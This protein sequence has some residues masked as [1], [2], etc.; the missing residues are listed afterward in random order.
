MATRKPPDAWY[1]SYDIK[2]DE[3]DS[4]LV[5]GARLMRL[6]SYRKG[7]SLRFAA[8]AYQDHGPARRHASDLD[9]DAAAKLLK[10]TGE[11]PVAVTV[12]AAGGAP[13]FSLV[14]ETGPGPVAALHVD[15]DEAGVRALLDE[16]HGIADLA[17]YATAAGRRYAAIIEERA[18]PSWLFTG[19]TGP[20]LDAALVE[21]GAQLVRVRGYQE[22]GRQLFAAVA[23]RAEGGTWAWYAALDPD[24]VA[25]NLERNGAYPLDL[26][27][28]RDEQGLRFCVVMV[29]GA[30]SI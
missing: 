29:R 24:A 20:E 18:A 4:V 6:S 12:D 27:A 28:S 8:L 17:T 26:D 25:R 16:K 21:R 23:E 19:V 14:I 13:R 2:P 15:L 3:I 5:P 9:A 7:T 30:Q 22:G 11:R 1:W 10:E